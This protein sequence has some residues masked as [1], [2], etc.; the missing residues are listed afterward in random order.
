[1]LSL[2]VGKSELE[3]RVDDW[4]PFTGT[5]PAAFGRIALPRTWIAV[6]MA[7]TATFSAA[8]AYRASTEERKSVTCE[9]QLGEAQTYELVQRQRYLAASVEYERWSN[10]FDLGQRR[11]SALLQRAEVIRDVKNFGETEAGLLDVEA[12]IDNAV[13]RILQPVRDLTNPHLEGASNLERRLR[14]RA[15]QDTRELGIANRCAVREAELADPIEPYGPVL[16]EGPSQ[17]ENYLNALRANVASIHRKSLDDAVA[18]VTFVSVLVIFTLSRLARGWQRIVLL[19]AAIV[20]IPVSFLFAITRSD[21]GLARYTST[22]ALVIVGFLILGWIAWKL[23]GTPISAAAHTASASQ[24]D[25][26]NAIDIDDANCDPTE[27]PSISFE[28][29]DAHPYDRVWTNLRSLLAIGGIGAAVLGTIAWYEVNV[30][31]PH[32]LRTGPILVTSAAILT[33]YGFAAM[34]TTSTLETLRASFAGN[35]ERTAEYRLAFWY[36]WCSLVG[37]GIFALLAPVSAFL[38]ER[39]SIGGMLAA[40]AVVLALAI[41]WLI[42]AMAQR[43]SLKRRGHNIGSRSVAAFPETGPVPSAQSNAPMVAE[44]G[45]SPPPTAITEGSFAEHLVIHRLTSQQFAR[46]VVLLITLT[47]LSSAVLTY[48]Y[49]RE[50]GIANEFSAKASDEQIELMRG[51]SRQASIAYRT[52][53]ALTALREARLRNAAA[54]QLRDEAARDHATKSLAVWDH[55]LRR[56]APAL[57]GFSDREAPDPQDTSSSVPLNQIFNGEYGPEADLTF[58]A[59][60]YYTSTIRSAAERLALWDAY[61]EANTAAEGRAGILLAAGT[62]FAIALYLLGQSLGTG[63]TAAGYVLA[64]M[65]LLLLIFGIGVASYGITRQVPA[66]NDVVTVPE[67]CRTGDE[68]REVTIAN[69]AATCYGYAE[70]LVAVA[71]TPADFKRAEYAYETATL[72]TMRPG[73]VISRYRALRVMARTASPQRTDYISIVHPPMLKSIVKRE[74]R[75]I[76]DLPSRDRVAPRSLHEIAGFHRYLMALYDSDETGLRAS[77]DELKRSERSAAAQFRLGIAYLA[78]GEHKNSLRA[79]RAAYSS[80]LMSSEVAAAALTDLEVLGKKCSPF[81]LLPGTQRC[82]KELR[83]IIDVREAQIVRTA[84]PTPSTEELRIPH[85]RI[86]LASGAPNAI[87]WSAR[88]SEKLPVDV[89]LVMIVYQFERTSKKGEGLW[90]AVASASGPIERQEMRRRGDLR[91]SGIRAVV[92]RYGS[93]QCLEKDTT[94]RIE[95][96]L[97]GEALARKTVSI[98]DSVTTYDGRAL[99]EQGVAM[100]LPR[101]WLHAP[102]RPDHVEAS[103]RSPEGHAGAD[104]YSFFQPRHRSLDSL[105]S[106]DRYRE[107]AIQRTLERQQ[108]QSLPARHV[109]G[110]EARCRGPEDQPGAHTMVHSTTNLTLLSKT[111]RSKDGL[112][113]VVLAWYDISGDSRSPTVACQ[114][115]S[116]TAST[117]QLTHLEL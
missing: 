30:V 54:G 7:I 105:D 73:F 62:F 41:T 104:I 58:P 97:H 116:S 24:D 98:P 13:T 108:G 75:L 49:T 55:E 89:P 103:F 35:S 114:V 17:F 29:T 56:L 23:H 102:A 1:L 90:Y 12:Q 11:G 81:W 27:R 94:Y 82:S 16:A 101:P 4:K 36:T 71:R 84:W 45:E 51:T 66:I 28:G 80:P 34:L 20:G 37:T 91:I 69:A 32:E 72:E 26:F 67:Q 6:L 50:A 78:A 31:T 42:I 15:E 86:D 70:S 117:D 85:A 2:D 39:R 60:L 43:S 95:L 22:P 77:V 65:G 10:R 112:V 87:N 61:D 88:L 83:K 25:E 92:N 74:E 40:L 48:L 53:E 115:L 46:A 38:V 68:A 63:N 52:I 76:S 8:A 99:Q 106:P 110:T 109:P 64:L 5:L 111:W 96:R 44:L 9:H 14:A 3:G 47:A 59:K 113:H 18:V 107:A 93:V 19:I 79:Y 33:A 57:D 21:N 100:C